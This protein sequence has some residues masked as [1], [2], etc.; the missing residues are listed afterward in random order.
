MSA[1]PTTGSK[2]ARWIAQA[3]PRVDNSASFGAIAAHSMSLLRLPVEH[4]FAL[5][6]AQEVLAQPNVSTESWYPIA[7]RT[8]TCGIAFGT[9]TCGAAGTITT[10]KQLPAASRGVTSVGTPQAGQNPCHQ[11]TAPESIRQRIARR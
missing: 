5:Q 11:T 9:D 4:R 7:K 3:A 6:L 1:A 2:F 8:S 10:V